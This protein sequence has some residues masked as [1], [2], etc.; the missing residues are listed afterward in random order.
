M[1]CF[2]LPQEI[3][4]IIESDV[5]R[6][7]W[8]SK[9]ENRS[10][11]WVRKEK[12][13][14]STTEGG[15]GF[16]SL[17]DFNLAMLAKQIWRLHNNPNSLIAKCF[18]AKY[19]PTT[20]VLQ[21]PIGVN[22]SYAWRCMQQSI[23]ILNKGCCWR[24]GNGQ[25]I[26]IWGDNWLPTH[27]GLK[28]ISQNINNPI[29]VLVKDL[30]EGTPPKWNKS[31]IEA[32]FLPIDR[33]Q[34]QQIPI[35]YKDKENTL[36]WTFSET[37]D[38]TVKTGYQA[39]QIWKHNMDQ[40]SSN[41]GSMDQVWKRVWGIETIPRH[42]VFL[43]RLLHKALPV[44]DE[45][46]KKGI[47]CPLMCPRC[48][49][50][51]ENINHL[52]IHCDITKKEWFGSKLG[53]NFQ[54]SE[55][56]DFTDWLMYF[57][58]NN[59]SDS[60][61]NIAALLYSIWQARNQKKFDNID[62]PG[63]IVIQRADSSICNYRKAQLADP[64][65]IDSSLPSSTQH[66]VS[67]PKH[68]KWKKPEKDIIKLNSDANL[69][70]TDL[71]GIG[72]VARNDEGFT[73]ASGT[74]FRFGFPSATTAE[75]WG[76][77]QAMIFAGECGFSKVQFESDNE[78]VIQMLN[79]TEEV[80]RLY[81]GSIIDS[82]LSLRSH[83]SQCIFSHTKRTSNALAHF[84]AQLATRDPDKVCMEDVPS[85]ASSLYFSDIIS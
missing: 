40:G 69:S 34:I 66:R 20:N 12:L 23:W 47:R 5:C 25:K 22:P 44:R 4:H 78:R 56:S 50:G 41:T 1:S 37:G 43:W 59:D 72:V 9:G 52:F 29:I 26:K 10:I 46:Y 45:L 2:L 49:S 75:A 73:M 54:S 84:L 8:G 28:I 48:E 53:I 57:I 61:I 76:I 7:W 81:L 21:A 3:C 11:H 71:W 79:G 32:T 83:F 31:L 51:I 19:Y 42:K 27:N 39:I 80:N 60:I 62:V 65:S 13:F 58:L 15:L 63:E 38:Y 6:F 35:T 68:V 17:R 55:I 24:V 33:V 85:D 14:K 64:N 74:W 82:I 67:V 77:Y 18:K 30:L 70:S 36:M 16:R